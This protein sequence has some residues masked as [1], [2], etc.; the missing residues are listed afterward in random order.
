MRPW[1]LGAT[2]PPP[3]TNGAE[4]VCTCA[5]VAGG[6]LL[7]W[8]AC[9]WHDTQTSFHAKG[10]PFLVDAC[11]GGQG[12]VQCAP[13]Y[14]HAPPDPM[15]PPCPFSDCIYYA[16]I[17]CMIAQNDYEMSERNFP[18]DDRPVPQQML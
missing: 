4:Y 11:H 1:T 5:E 7:K 16:T 15:H 18:H 8:R 2:P 12:R 9:G 3:H 14:G 10:M 17:G 13:A 6:I